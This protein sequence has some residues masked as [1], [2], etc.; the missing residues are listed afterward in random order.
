MISVLLDKDQ[1]LFTVYIK[2]YIFLNKNNINLL[3]TSADDSVP[4]EDNSLGP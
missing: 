1:Q 3:V 4:A 2:E